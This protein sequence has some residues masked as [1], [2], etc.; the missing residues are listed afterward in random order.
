[1]MCAKN[2]DNAR[3]RTQTLWLAQIL[4]NIMHLTDLYKDSIEK[5]M[6]ESYRWK[7]L[8]QVDNYSKYLIPLKNEKHSTVT[9]AMKTPI[10]TLFIL[11]FYYEC[12][13]TYVDRGNSLPL[14]PLG[15]IFNF[16]HTWRNRLHNIIPPVYMYPLLG[17]VSD[18][19]RNVPDEFNGETNTINAYR[20][21][22]TKQWKDDIVKYE[23]LKDKQTAWKAL[24]E[25]QRLN[26]EKPRLNRKLVWSKGS[27]GGHTPS[28]AKTE[29]NALFKDIKDARLDCKNQASQLILGENEHAGRT[30]TTGKSISK[31]LKST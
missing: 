18:L 24:S 2:L 8:K 13:H 21:Y 15:H 12:Y 1:M 14:N 25:R 7:V 3:L 17:I 27:W 29:L 31:S 23:K 11:D 4:S 19:Y 20:K 30:G 6:S 5:E 16:V 9:W 28:F 22:L 26:T 10:H